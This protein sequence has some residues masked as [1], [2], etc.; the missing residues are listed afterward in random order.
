MFA[1]GLLLAL[2]QY[3][4]I[5][6]LSRCRIEKLSDMSAF[7]NKQPQ[8]ATFMG[9]TWGPAGSCGPTNLAIRD[10]IYLRK[11]NS[12]VCVMSRPLTLAGSTIDEVVISITS[13]TRGCGGTS[14][15]V[16]QC[17]VHWKTNIYFSYS[18]TSCHTNQVWTSP[19]LP[20]W[21]AGKHMCF[22]AM[23]K[24]SFM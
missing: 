17:A 16:G 15:T 23:A 2:I 22:S 8:M 21:D 3:A 11:L 1:S 14:H 24:H 18:T 12:E 20:Q 13:Q 9:P 7:R 6:F 5:Y 10:D 4:N 19:M